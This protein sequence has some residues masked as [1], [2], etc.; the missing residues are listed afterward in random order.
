MIKLKE[1][2]EK[3]IELSKRIARGEYPSKKV[4]RVAT[5]MGSFFGSI[6]LIIGMIATFKGQSWGIGCL[7]IGGLTIISN[8]INFKKMK[9][10]INHD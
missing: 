7:L 9:K 2:N 6:L 1:H 3:Y 4:I 5:I 10:H 8:F